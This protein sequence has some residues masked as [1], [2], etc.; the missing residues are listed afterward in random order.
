MS[1]SPLWWLAIVSLAVSHALAQNQQA[2]MPNLIRFSGTISARAGATA[3]VT[4]ALYE[5]ERGGAPLWMETRNVRLD[6]MGHYSA[7]LGETKVEGVPLELFASGEARWL[8]VQVEQQPEQ[9]R[10]LLVAVPYALKAHDADTLA[11]KPASAYLLSPQA[12][13]SAHASGVSRVRNA[14]GTATTNAITGSGSAGFMAKWTANTSVGNSVLFQDSLG[15]VGLGT[16]APAATL[17]VAGNVHSSTIFGE[18][19][20]FSDMPD[21]VIGVFGK[22]NFGIGV[23]G[24]GGAQG[25]SFSGPVAGAFTSDS[26]PIIASNSA[27]IVFRVDGAGNVSGTSVTFGD[28]TTQT[29]AAAPAVLSGFCTG[30]FTGPG[31]AYLYQLGEVDVPTCGGTNKPSGVPMPS[32][33]MLR[34]LR[35]AVSSGGGITVTVFVNG[36]ATNLRCLLSQTN[37][38]CGDTTHKVSIHAGDIVAVHYATTTAAAFKQLRVAME[39]Q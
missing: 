30:S 24:V 26:L 2:V 14:N 19:T 22:S 31:A 16:S 9:P 27:G 15:R 34:N 4:F 3:G 8:G 32:A 37:G 17:D 10:V 7:L 35:A 11:G 1:R 21:E 6:R 38:G 13:T 25:G 23:V 18:N 29:T 20:A 33:G 39:K 5:D 12:D 28:F 36:S